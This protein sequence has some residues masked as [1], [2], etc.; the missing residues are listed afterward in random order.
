MNPELAELF[1]AHIAT[2]GER[3]D[4]ALHATGFDH[5]LIYGG[6]LHYA[7][8]DDYAMP[9]KVN[10][11]F[12]RWVPVTDN[13]QCL[14]IYTPGKKP[15]LAFYSPVDFWHKTHPV[16][17][18]FWTKHFDIHPIAGIDE[19][20]ALL[21]AKLDRAAFIGEPQ[22]LFRK[23]G[24][25]NINPEDL[26]HHLHYHYAWKTEYELECLREANRLGARGHLAAE[27]AFRA[28]AS[29]YDIHFAYLQAS[30]H[31][32]NQ[33]PYGNIIALNENA[34]I[35]H[36][37]YQSRTAP[38]ESRSFLIDAGCTFNGYASDITRTYSTKNNEFQ[39]LID[40]MEMSQRGLC[41]AVRP[42]MNYLE[43]QEL[44][45]RDVARIL[46]DFDIAK[47]DA[48]S[49]V[50]RGVTRPFFPHGV[51]HYLGA[52]VHDV[53][54]KISDEKGTPIRQPESQP[55]LRLTRDI[56][57]NQVF[58]IE[59]GLYFIDSL[60]DELKATDAGSSVNWKRI[61]D[62]RPF[63]GIRIEDNIRVTQTGHENLTRPAFGLSLIHI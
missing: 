47:G 17:D 37:Q 51:G 42:G 54:G 41:D 4:V 43:L 35:L 22:P 6:E 8:L 59:P 20:A 5:L 33:L 23:W 31:T 38:R 52:Q 19:A 34:A 9:F 39:E 30:S 24:V 29:E 49:L 14:L 56:D 18:E 50:E 10:P 36:Y 25:G 12:K 58:T 45:H 53:G 40:R 60:L 28:G 13:P 27:K 48:D 44:A 32:E 26:I 3:A 15:K 55:Y 46:I 21:P 1:S 61:D 62:F 7:F 11:Q 2:L 16:P 63:G 57:A